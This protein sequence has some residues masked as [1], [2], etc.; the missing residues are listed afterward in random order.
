MG[1]SGVLCACVVLPSVYSL[2]AMFLDAIG[3]P[4]G[5]SARMRPIHALLN[6]VYLIFFPRLSY[7]SLFT[8]NQKNS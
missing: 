3:E 2:G 1:E 5:G 7:F 8:F 4:V 6:K